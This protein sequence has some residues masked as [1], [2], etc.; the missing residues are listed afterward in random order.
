MRLDCDL[1]WHVLLVLVES[2]YNI[3]VIVLSVRAEAQFK[4]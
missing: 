4:T 2:I 1:V 3:H